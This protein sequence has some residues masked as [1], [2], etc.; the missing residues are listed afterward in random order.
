MQA[1]ERIKYY[2]EKILGISQAK[3]AKKLKISASN[4]SNIE[5]ARVAL[6]NRVLIDIC[7]AYDLNENWVKY[8]KE[9]IKKSKSKEEEM[10][11]FLK[12]INLEDNVIAQ[13]F[14]LSLSK[15]SFDEW[16]LLDKMIS[17]YIGINK[18][19]TKLKNI[20]NDK[21]DCELSREE[22]HKLIDLELDAVEKRKILSVSTSTNFLGENSKKY[23][24]KKEK[25]M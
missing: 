8:G 1:Y 5:I 12:K 25:A 2:R 23:K 11:D 6:T 7:E 14:I 16:I 19:V 20:I 24:N 4:Y 22:I 13:R 9:P 18:E 10:L 21:T 17:N 3:F 15:L